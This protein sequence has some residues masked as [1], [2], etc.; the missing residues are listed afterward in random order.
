MTRS[1]LLPAA[2]A[3]AIPL[4]AASGGCALFLPPDG[5]PPARPVPLSP[6]VA[7]EVVANERTRFVW[8]PVDGA[9]WYDFHVFDRSTRDI[10]RYRVDGL[11]ARDVCGAEACTH[12]TSLSLPRMADH[13]WRVR[14]GNRSGVSGWSRSRFAMVDAGGGPRTGRGGSADAGR[15]RASAGSSG[16]AAP[17]VLGP[18]GATFRAD[19]LVT[20][21]WGA[22]DGASGYDFHLFDATSRA[23]VEDVRGLDPDEVC[24]ASGRC[25]I[26]AVVALPPAPNHA[27]RVRA[28]GPGG[29]SGWTRTTL[30]V[31][32]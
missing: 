19:D 28:T 22:V 8:A 16:P 20:F 18:V 30:D 11:A 9:L 25:A 5:D 23:L 14:A 7:A 17:A 27:W 15:A 1:R 12:E 4:A 6:A 3:L 13:A 29:A 32:R 26:D 24:D 31:A 10:G 21:E 2:A